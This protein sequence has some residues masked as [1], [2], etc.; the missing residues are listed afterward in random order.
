M[1]KREYRII[2]TLL[3][4]SSATIQ[5]KNRLYLIRSQEGGEQKREEGVGGERELKILLTQKTS[6]GK[7]LKYQWNLPSVYN[8]P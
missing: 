3:G 2:N 7:I 8:M 5:G 4:Y 1:S 6:W